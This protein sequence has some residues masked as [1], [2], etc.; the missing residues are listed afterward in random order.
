M[1]LLE[2]YVW[3]LVYWGLYLPITGMISQSMGEKGLLEVLIVGVVMTFILVIGLHW[4]EGLFFLEL[5]PAATLE[6]QPVPTFVVKKPRGRK[7]RE[8][9]EQEKT[10]EVNSNAEEEQKQESVKSSTIDDT[11][12]PEPKMRTDVDL[13]ELNALDD[14]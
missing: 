3:V 9:I 2:M 1:K 5:E 4:F 12:E 10:L 6:E 11:R 7:P 13:S 8:N 14:D